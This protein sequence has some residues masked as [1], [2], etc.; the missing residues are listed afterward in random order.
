MGAEKPKDM[1]AP[2]NTS[3]TALISNADIADWLAT[4]HSFFPLSKRWIDESGS[5]PV[6]KRFCRCNE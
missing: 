1:K 2:Q 5:D 6:P 4:S 3:S